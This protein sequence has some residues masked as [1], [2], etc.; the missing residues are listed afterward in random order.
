MVYDRELQIRN[1]KSIEHYKVEVSL[2]ANGVDFKALLE[3]PENLLTDGYL[4][5]KSHAEQLVN[6]FLPKSGFIVESFDRKK[7]KESAPLPYDLSSLQVDASKFGITPAKTLQ[8]VQS[9]YDQPLSAVTYPRTD[10]KYLPESMIKDVTKTLT[11]LN[12]VVP[13]FSD[14]KVDSEKKVKCFND[15]KVT[16]HHA[17]IPT[18]KYIDLSKLTD[19]QKAIYILIATR[20]FQQFMDSYEFDKTKALFKSSNF[21][22]IAKGKVTTNKGWK[23]LS[24]SNEKSKNEELPDLTSSQ[25]V[26]FLGYRLITCKTSAPKRF[27][28]GSLVELMGNPAGLVRDEQFKELVSKSDGIG[29][30]A[31]RSD[32][33]QK[34]VSSNLIVIQ[35]GMAKP[36]KL[37]NENAQYLS[38]F[39]VESSVL[40]QQK[41]SSAAENCMTT[42]A[43]YEHFT[44]QTKFMVQQWKKAS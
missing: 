33:I 29:T 27:T 38:Q 20:Y 18:S 31:T 26:Q 9:L 24:S 10:S 25:H 14:F 23:S 43:L 3:I 36:G 1:F 35:N 32:V 13:K 19:S 21:S 5:N 39:S 8:L 42:E 16:A 4:I 37:I 12:K 11:T 40:M 15:K 44:K 28:E 7:S 22:F 6:K 17:I 34:A 30:P 41:L 2:Q